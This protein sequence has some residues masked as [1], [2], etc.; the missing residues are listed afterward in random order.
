MKSSPK[1]GRHRLVLCAVLLSGLLSALP[2]F[3]AA[4]TPQAQSLFDNG[5]V[6]YRARHYAEALA[7]FEAADAAGMS[8]PNLRFN[9]GLSQYQLGHLDQARAQFEILRA[10][11]DYKSIADYHLGLIAARS[12]DRSAALRLLQGVEASAPTPQLRNLAG[13]A[14][15]R[16]RAPMASVA[17]S[18]AYL[19]A[20]GGYDSNPV[21]IADDS[22]LG[23]GDPFAELLGVL[24]YPLLNGAGSALLVEATGYARE[25]ADQSDFS[26]E[27]ALLGLRYEHA[28][29]GGQLAISG[30]GEAAFIG[31]DAFQTG[32]GLAAEWRRSGP[33][34]GLRIQLQ[35]TRLGGGSGY[36]YL[37]GWR[38]R[39]L[40]EYAPK[41]GAGRLTLGYD[42]EYNDRRDLVDGSDFYSRSPLRQR[43]GIR[44]SLPLASRLSLDVDARYRDSRYRSRDRYLDNG[45][46]VLKRR[47]EQLAEAGL[48]LRYR[49]SDDWSLLAQY[50]FQ[51]NN[52]N[53]AVY[54]YD[55]HTVLVTAEWLT[56]GF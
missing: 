14:L 22:N 49:V 50:Q 25:Y 53:I 35:G 19:S 24:S 12:G 18:S 31:G 39:A 20:G 52:A 42:V 44:W 10:M 37:D 45:S 1:P 29:G 55:R 5:V 26:Q 36:S 9:L 2:A 38:H 16:L 51:H 48:S 33:G 6:Q 47:K 54:D 8:S 23:G 27:A 32:G 56:A 34:A 28:V 7:A 4:T 21:L 11:P 30:Q 3:P 15:G 43:I 41:L 40:V 13:T 17:V 46:P